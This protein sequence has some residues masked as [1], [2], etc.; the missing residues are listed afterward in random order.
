M[1]KQMMHFGFCKHFLTFL[2][3]EIRFGTEVV[4][5]GMTASGHIAVNVFNEYQWVET[6]VLFKFLDDYYY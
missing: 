1:D 2:V 3:F 4:Y 6:I 5:L